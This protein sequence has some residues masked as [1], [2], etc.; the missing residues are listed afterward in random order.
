M[1]PFELNKKTQPVREMPVFNNWKVVARAW[2]FALRSDELAKG[3]TK[4][5]TLCRQKIALFRGEDGTVRAIDAYCPH[6]GVDLSLGKVIG[7]ELRCFFHHWQ[8]NGEGKCTKIPAADTISPRA[9]LHSWAAEEKY[10]LIWIFPDA[11]ADF[12]LP[13]VLALDGK[14]VRGFPG[15]SFSRNCHHHINMI[16][17]IDPQHLRTVHNMKTDMAVRALDQKSEH[18][19]EYVLEGKQSLKHPL[20]R[21]IR[22]LTGGGFTYSM[23][24]SGGTIGCISVNQNVRLRGAGWTLPALHMIFAYRPN[25][26]LEVTE[27]Q[28]IHLVPK[29]RGVLGAIWDGF[30]LRMTSFVFG[31]L[32]DEDGMIYDN[33]RFRPNALLPLDA[34]IAQY[35]AHVNRLKPS[36]WSEE[37]SQDPSRRPNDERA[38]NT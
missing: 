35:M 10:G 25:R 17:G 12:P 27:V 15:K 31:I 24:F 30:L 32:R 7:N 23:R 26:D 18:Q 8:F 34:P 9:T 21:I 4:S 28:T 37:P 11:Q 14:E 13:G 29:H 1:D 19:I 2:Y 3:K 16:N 5:I 36:I 22:W 33:I 6:M 20:A 38:P